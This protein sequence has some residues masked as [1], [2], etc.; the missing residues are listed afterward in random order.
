VRASKGQLNTQGQ[1]SYDSQTGLLQV[2]LNDGQSV[3]TCFKIRERLYLVKE[4]SFYVTQDDGVNEPAGSA[5]GGTPWPVQEVSKKVG[6]PS[7]NGVGIGEDWV[8]IAHRTGLYI[9]HGGEPEKISQEIQPLWDTINWQYGYT[10]SVTVD[11]R[12]RRILICAPF[13]AATAPNKT[14]VLDYHDVGGADQ[15]A[16]SPPIHLTYTGRKAAFDKSR[17]W[18]P[19]TI[20]ANCVAQI[21][22]SNLQ[23]LLYFGSND[24]TG[25]INQLDDTGNVFADNGG[26]IPSYYVTAFFV[27]QPQEQ[28]LQLRT[29][30]KLFQYMTQFVQG[31][32]TM[33]LTVYLASLSNALALNPQA[34]TNPAIKDLEV[35]LNQLIERMAVKVAAGGVAG[36]WFDLQK[37]TLAVKPDPWALVRGTN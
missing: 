37:T 2:S 9:F 18:A 8:V 10:I 32:G 28:Q 19:W 23:T 16:S 34:L 36:N 35:G 31:S 3:R 29:H 1:E 4:H 30:R 26:Q 20:A 24:G 33:G 15:I 27:E 25:N 7:I 21:E 22:Q 12:K 13:G 14:V 11:T 17:K 6:T 5:T